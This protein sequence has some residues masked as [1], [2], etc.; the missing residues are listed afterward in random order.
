MFTTSK[1]F[2]TYLWQCFIIL[3][4]ILCT[5]VERFEEVD[6]GRPQN[7]IFEI[8]SGFELYRNFAKTILR[9]NLSY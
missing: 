5:D 2:I 4:N 6:Q 9:L 3:I 1:L 7:E 8:L